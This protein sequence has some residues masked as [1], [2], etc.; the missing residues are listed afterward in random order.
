MSALATCEALIAWLTPDFHE[1]LWTDQE[2]GFCV[3]RSVLIIPIRVG[4]NPYG[5][6]GK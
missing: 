3:G 1:S 2:V 6:I 5:F 4:L